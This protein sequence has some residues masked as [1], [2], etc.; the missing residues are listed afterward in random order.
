MTAKSLPSN[1]EPIK[2]V[3]MFSGGIGSWATAKRVSMA[4][5][6]D[7]LVLLF[8]DTKVEDVD[9]YR[10]LKSAHRNVGGELVIVEDGR[11][12]F[13]V[14]HD[15]RFLGNSRLANCSKFLKQKPCREWLEANCDPERTI[16][17]VGIDWSEA[18]RMAAI[19][20]G[21]APYKVRAPMT[22][23][24][25]LSK[26]Q[27]LDWLKA[28]R[29]KA[30]RAYAEGFPHNNCLA[31]GCVR[32]G[33]A[34]WATLFRER[35]AAYRES[36]MEEQR[37]REHLG[38]DVSILKD[39]TRGRTTTLTLK[40]FRERLQAQGSFDALEWGACGCFVDDDPIDVEKAA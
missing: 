31:Q 40:G 1:G 35:P 37:L 32:G 21:W 24:P 4:V 29:L 34:Y 27:V 17:Y 33:Q 7:S 6:P 25:Y 39:R 36:E 10:F 2:H 13:E 14:F 8:A 26:Q 18:H 11:T 9:L 23:R 28:E 3:V 20:N 12:P 30:P 38:A 22:T 15:D 19:I 16:V 5:S